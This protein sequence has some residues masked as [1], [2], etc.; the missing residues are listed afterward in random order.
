MRRS[1]VV[2]IFVLAAT[3]AF[4]PAASSQPAETKPQNFKATLVGTVV[5]GAGTCCIVSRFFEGSAVVPMLGRVTFQGN[6]SEGF[7]QFSDPVTRHQ[8]LSLRLV[9]PSGDALVLAGVTQWFAGDPMPALTWNVSEAT[10]RFAA[11]AGSGTYTI[12]SVDG[13]VVIALSGTL[14]KAG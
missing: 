13:D 1:G 14:L 10:G 2:V 9:S 4:A 8:S 6:W 7:V 12:A 3:L 11:Y 5:G